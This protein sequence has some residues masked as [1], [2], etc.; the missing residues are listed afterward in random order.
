MKD[1]G[2]K[3]PPFHNRM[4]F[5]MNALSLSTDRNRQWITTSMDR[6]VHLWE[7]KSELNW[8]AAKIKRSLSCLGGEITCM[9]IA[10]GGLLAAGCA[11]K[12]IRF[13]SME[14]ENTL[15]KIKWR[16]ISETVAC[17]KWCPSNRKS[18]HL[19]VLKVS[20]SSVSFWLSKWFRWIGWRSGST[21]HLSCAL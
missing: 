17:I 16:G 19:P 7:I 21:F 13:V 15:P 1:S 12:T 6:Y 2:I 14:N 5:T 20:F 18:F 4:I 3:L 8:E 9:D 11:D 10:K